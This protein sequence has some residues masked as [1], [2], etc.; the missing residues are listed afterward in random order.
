MTE[1]VQESL[2]GNPDPDPAP[3]AEVATT[4][5]A[6]NDDQDTESLIVAGQSVVMVDLARLIRMW[7]V[8]SQ[9]ELYLGL[10]DDFGLANEHTQ[11]KRTDLN[12]SIRAWNER[13]AWLRR[14]RGDTAPDDQ[15]T[16]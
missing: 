11:S 7:A 5:I 1:A 4:T 16:D 2:F 12:K 9:T 8:A 13:D 15:P 10:E 6:T 14:Q 3:V